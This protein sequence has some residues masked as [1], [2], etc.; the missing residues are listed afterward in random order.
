MW[1]RQLHVQISATR[2]VIRYLVLFTERHI[3]QRALFFLWMMRFYPGE[4]SENNRRDKAIP[5]GKFT[6]TISQHNITVHILK[7]DML[8]C[9]MNTIPEILWMNS[10]PELKTYQESVRRFLACTIAHLRSKF[11]K[12]K[13]LLNCLQFP[14]QTF[15]TY[16]DVKIISKA[17]AWN[18]LSSKPPVLCAMRSQSKKSDTSQ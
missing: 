9:F 14:I 15:F 2:N 8:N 17:A 18:F 11:W 5:G 7:W 12:F 4:I 1:L 16:V 10:S 6:C 3:W 13:L